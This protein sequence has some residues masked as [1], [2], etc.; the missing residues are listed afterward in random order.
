[1]TVHIDSLEIIIL[2]HHPVPT[3]IVVGHCVRLSVSLRISVIG[4]KFGG[5]MQSNMKQIA[6]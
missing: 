1:M 6:I 4:L 3:G 5:M 2:G